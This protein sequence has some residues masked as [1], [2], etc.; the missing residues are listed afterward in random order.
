MVDYSKWDHLDDE[1]DEE[2][3][4]S[5][6]EAEE[7]AKT[8]MNLLRGRQMAEGVFGEVTKM[9]ADA[10]A[11]VGEATK[12]Q[13]SDSD[14]EKRND[15]YNKAI[16]TYQEILDK[17]QF[18][19]VGYKTDYVAKIE[20]SIALCHLRRGEFKESAVHSTKSFSGGYYQAL[21]IRAIAFMNM[22]EREQALADCRKARELG[23][24]DAEF[25]TELDLLMGAMTDLEASQADEGEDAAD[26]S[27]ASTAA[28]EKGSSGGCPV[29]AVLGK[30]ASIWGLLGATVALI[31]A[32]LV[33][34]L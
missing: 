30:F 1:E 25:V 9:K 22:Q 23:K 15:M 20:F 29:P 14:E 10:D 27:A 32:V 7:R 8:T 17:D 26:S 18:A 31:V 12:L 21:Q 4:M 34:R 24:D 19:G 5:L 2:E 6:V 13:K 3:T 33:H 16:Q 28:E 11:L